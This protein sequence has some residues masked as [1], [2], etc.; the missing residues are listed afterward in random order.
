MVKVMVLL[1]ACCGMSVTAAADTVVLHDVNLID[2]NGGAPRTHT[3]V[4]IQDGHI[5]S[6]QAASEKSIK[7]TVINLS[8]R[9]VLPGLISDHSHLGL[10]DGKNAGGQY[11]TTTNILRQLQQYQAYGVTTVVSLGLNQ[12]SFYDLAPKI[13][14]GELPGADMFGADRGFGVPDG[15]PPA[16]MGITEAQVYRPS[17]IEEARA[18]VRE[19]A[20]RHPTFVKIWVDD[21]HGQMPQKLSPPI[22][23]AIIEE[24]HAQGLRVAAHVYYLAD[25]KQLVADGVDVLAHG[26]RD[27]PVD[28]E[29]IAAVKAHQVWYIPTLGLDESAYLFAEHPELASQPFLAHALQPALTQQLADPA[30]RANILSNAKKLAADKSSLSM[31]E[32]NVKTLYDAG[33]HIGFGTDSGATPLRIAGFAEHRELELLVASG[34][35]P[36]QAIGTATKNAAGLLKLEDRGTVAPGKRADLLVVEGDPSEQITDVNRIV[37]VWRHGKQVAAGLEGQTNH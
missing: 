21:F 32:R 17:T 22:Y 4:V 34:L 19:T 6:I 26:V 3:D 16:T 37:S 35:T 18:E 29:F 27:V 33:V 5:A 30:W 11:A 25:A 8:G 2:G 36:L 31:N 10:T 7:G 15:A 1:L 13:H 12:Q 14:S 24:A 23:K 28:P 9:T 20:S